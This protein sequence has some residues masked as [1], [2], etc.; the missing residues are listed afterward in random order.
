MKDKL[1]DN[2]TPAG[3]SLFNGFDSFMRDLSEHDEAVISGGAN[4]N[5]RSRPKK[6]RRPRRSVSRT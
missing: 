1:I 4:S 3:T 6:R 5:S 2:L